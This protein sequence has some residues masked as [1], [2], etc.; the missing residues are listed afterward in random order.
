MKKTLLV[1]AALLT[2]TPAQA[3]MCDL[4][5][6]ETTTADMTTVTIG[7][8]THEVTGRDN[9]EAFE[10]QLRA[11]GQADA[12]DSFRKWRQMR[13]WT[14]EF[15]ACWLL[16]GTGVLPTGV[17]AYLAGQHREDMVA[18]LVD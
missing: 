4:T 18:A 9:R 1:I 10:A 6:F 3:A 17:T 11:C 16:V 5:H 15:A 7:G 13:R 8:V 14:N 2:A 12:A